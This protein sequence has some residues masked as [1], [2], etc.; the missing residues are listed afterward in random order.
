MAIKFREVHQLRTC[1][2]QRI[3]SCITRDQD[4]AEFVCALRK[5]TAEYCN[6]FLEIFPM[7]LIRPAIALGF[8][9]APGRYGDLDHHVMRF[10]TDGNLYVQLRCLAGREYRNLLPVLT[11]AD[12]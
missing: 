12:A 1:R 2:I 5:L 11:E 9:G 3:A 8:V 7:Y 6:F 4:K 10:V